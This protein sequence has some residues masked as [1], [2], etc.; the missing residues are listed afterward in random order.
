VTGNKIYGLPQD[1]LVNE[2][3]DG[4][5]VIDFLGWGRAAFEP[6][7]PEVMAA[8]GLDYSIGRDLGSIGRDL[9][10]EAA[11]ATGAAAMHSAAGR[12]R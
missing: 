9:G 12:A 6:A 5:A 10:G 4:N 11:W 7:M 1:R 3:V 2:P 8:G